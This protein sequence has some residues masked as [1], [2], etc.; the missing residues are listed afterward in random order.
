MYEHSMSTSLRQVKIFNKIYDL[1][2]AIVII[3]EN[4][5]YF[6]REYGLFPPMLNEPWN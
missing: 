3:C 1:S 2:Y 5:V 6:R 4:R